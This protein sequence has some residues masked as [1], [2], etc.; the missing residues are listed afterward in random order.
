MRKLMCM[1]LGHKYQIVERFTPAM[2]HI[3]CT[4]CGEHWGMNDDVRALVPW[5]EELEELGRDSKVLNREK[6]RYA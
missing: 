1:V 2:R 6:R 3:K 4:R 5:D